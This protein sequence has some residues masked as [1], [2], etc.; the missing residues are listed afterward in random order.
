VA[1]G[2]VAGE[3]L[4]VGWHS[5]TLESAADGSVLIVPNSDVSTVPVRNMSRRDKRIVR[6]TLQ[7]DDTEGVKHILSSAAGTRKLVFRL[8]RVLRTRPGVLRANGAPAGV[9][10]GAGAAPAAAAGAYIRP[11]FQL[12][13]SMFRGMRCMASVCQ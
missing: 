6:E 12:H 9:A 8:N 1:A 4:K 5:T 11:P 10:G 13:V 2:E 3:V 7:L